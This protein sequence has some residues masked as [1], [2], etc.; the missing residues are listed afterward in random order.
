MLRWWYIS[1]YTR[2]R[3]GREVHK[4]EDEIT[5]S[6]L[7]LNSTPD[8]VLADFLS[9]LLLHL[10]NLLV[11]LVD[12]VLHLVHLPVLHLV[13]PPPPNH[14]PTSPQQPWPTL[15]SPLASVAPKGVK[16][17]KERFFWDTLYILLQL[18]ISQYCFTTAIEATW[19]IGTNI[20][21]LTISPSNMTYSAKK[22]KSNQ[23]KSFIPKSYRSSILHRANA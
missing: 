17:L 23:T 7:T 2:C 19:H 12:L 5:R 11:F 22:S 4:M 20:F 16:I 3:K 1:R 10:V 15:L 13:H 21:C 18:H 8:H 6:D 9:D 14:H